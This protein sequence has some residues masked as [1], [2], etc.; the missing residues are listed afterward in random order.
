MNPVRAAVAGTMFLGELGD[1]ESAPAD[2]FANDGCG[3]P[4]D[5]EGRRKDE[6]ERDAGP[7]GKRSETEGRVTF[8]RKSLL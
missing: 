5:T 2:L 3:I 7:S 1:E 8:S 4:N 6:V